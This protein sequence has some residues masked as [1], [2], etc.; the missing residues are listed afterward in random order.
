MR[1]DQRGYTLLE[2]LIA[3]AVSAVVMA[4]V[5]TVVFTSVRQDEALRVRMEMQIEASR[6]MKELTTFLKS[7]G[8]VDVDKD[9]VFDYKVDMP[10]FTTEPLE[11][12]PRPAEGEVLAEGTFGSVNSDTVTFAGLNKHLTPAYKLSQKGNAQDFPENLASVEMMF[13]LPSD[14]QAHPTDANGNVQW[15]EDVFVICHEARSPVE[16]IENGNVLE[17]RRYTPV[18]GGDW[19]LVSR[20]VLAHWL[21]RILFE[22]QSNKWYV[23]DNYDATLGLDQIRITMWFRRN[24]ISRQRARQITTKQSSTVMFR[25]VDR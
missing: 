23:T 14:K 22:S 8:P 4:A 18:S 25:S 2:V 9:G 12:E 3:A 21:E 10:V 20:Q 24:D 1:R 5:F 15:G 6:A 11:F 19:T 13:R 17:L 7:A 16:W